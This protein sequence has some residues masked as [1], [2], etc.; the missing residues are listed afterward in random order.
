MESTFYAHD[1]RLTR[2][3]HEQETARLFKKGEGVSLMVADFV[4]ADYGWL[5]S[6]PVPPM[7]APVV[8]GESTHEGGTLEDARVV[9]CAGKQ[10]DGWFGTNH[11]VQQL[12][13]A[14]SIVK[15][16]YPH[17]EHVFIFDNATIHSK[18]PESAP[19]IYKMTLGP[20]QK[21]KGEEVGPSGEIIKIEYAPAILPDGTIQQ[22]YHPSNHPITDLQG[23]FKGMAL[24]LEERGIPGAQ[25]LKREC[26]STKQ[27]QGC[28]PGSTSCCAR[29]T[30]LNQ[31]DILA[32]KSILQIQAAAEGFSVMYLPK[33]HCELNPI[34]QCWGAAKR[35]YR[36][37]PSSSSEA[38][39][40]KNM[41]AALDSVELKSI[42]RYVYF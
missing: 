1:R 9:F 19:N 21:V 24:I 10:R 38:D 11:V 18:L 8:P 6:W 22:F 5:R 30:M 28:P 40:K 2:W 37:F 7:A 36:D 4:S 26:P 32:Q 16:H 41:L 13:R 20:S 35:V 12:S 42:R 14:M 3:I 15:K 27:R 33:Y 39:L 34:E 31:P 25:K 29:R 23:T 17:E